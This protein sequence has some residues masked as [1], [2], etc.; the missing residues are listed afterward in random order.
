MNKTFCKMPFIGM[1]TTHRGNRL[2]CASTKIINNDP[3]SFWKSDYLK[4]IR[5]KMIKGDTVEECSTCYINENRNQI[6]LRQHYNN[7]FKNVNEQEYPQYFDLDFS[8]LCNLQCIMCGPTRSSQWAKELGQKQITPISID[9]INNVLK[10]ST[11]L[12]HI[13]IQGGEPSIMPEFE[14]FF[15][16]LIEKDIAKNITVDCIS[17]LTNINNKF[18]QLLESFKSVNLNVSI[19]SYGS[20]NDYIRYPS[21]FNSIEKN[22]IKLAEKNIQT[23]LQITI[24]TLSMFNFYDFLNW[25]SKIYN[26]FQTKGKKLGFNIYFVHSPEILDIVYAPN[27]LKKDFVEQIKKFRLENTIK[28]DTKFN[29]SLMNLEKNFL[30]QHKTEK[31]KNILEYIDVL[32]HRRTI[33]ITNYIPNFY[34]YF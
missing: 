27:S 5:N 8:N 19:D 25:I 4:D 2:C 9:A 31:N 17:N 30:I 12:T 13:N 10:M 20:H 29:L 6:S 1:Q 16:Q 7:L 33:K 23:N 24:Q 11:N 32:D 15:E 34:N 14:Y 18:Y 3:K 21:N 26:I 28:F 22:L